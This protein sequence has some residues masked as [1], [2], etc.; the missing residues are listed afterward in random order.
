MAGP[1]KCPECGTGRTRRYQE[2]GSYWQ[3]SDCGLIGW[4]WSQEIARVGS[5]SGKKCPS[6]SKRTL[7]Q[8]V[9]LASGAGIRRCST[10]N[11][12]TIEP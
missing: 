6:C 7:H 12:T 1:R 9:Q 3:C 10:C 5:G 8:V 4:P 2:K 11:Y